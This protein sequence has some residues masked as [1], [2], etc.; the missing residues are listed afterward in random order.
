MTSVLTME[1]AIEGT[2]I[3]TGIGIGIGIGTGTTTEI[4]TGEAA[5]INGA[6][7][8]RIETETTIVVKIAD[9]IARRG[10]SRSTCVFLLQRIS[11]AK[12]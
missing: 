3:G 4:Q 5:M 2:G 1:M 7:A 11:R 12:F 10:L 8:G 9:D 6:I